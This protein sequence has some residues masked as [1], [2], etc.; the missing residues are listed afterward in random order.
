M[1][2]GAL[3]QLETRGV[4][5]RRLVQRHHLLGSA[6]PGIAQLDRACIVP[7]LYLLTQDLVMSLHLEYIYIMPTIILSL[8]NLRML[9]CYHMSHKHN[10]SKYLLK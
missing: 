3:S 4:S 1:E 2:L 8:I 7:V 10:Y 6:S 9:A 5:V